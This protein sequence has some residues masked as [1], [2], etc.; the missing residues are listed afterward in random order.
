MK[1]LLISTDLMASSQ[2]QGAAM[3]LGAELVTCS[4]ETAIM[5]AAAESPTLVVIDLT[6]NVEDIAAVVS[7]AGEQPVVAFGPHVHK[8]KLAAAAE[9]GCA[10]V[11][12]RGKFCRTA[13][14]IF[15]RYSP[16]A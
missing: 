8:K 9:A 11:F 1:I 13:A 12:T 6:A 14:K 2:I 10:E 7:A 4:P 16:A 3:S 5:S 15:S